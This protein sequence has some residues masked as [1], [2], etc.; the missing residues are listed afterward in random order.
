MAQSDVVRSNWGV[1]AFQQDLIDGIL[2]RLMSVLGT[3][4]LGGCSFLN[5][6][7]GGNGSLGGE[8]GEHLSCVS[9]HITL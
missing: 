8:E 2:M 4:K 3:E 9:G 5:W 6:K 7:D 1:G